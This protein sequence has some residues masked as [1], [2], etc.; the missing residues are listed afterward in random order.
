MDGL[1]CIR[2]HARAASHVSGDVHTFFKPRVFERSI[3][4]F[5]YARSA[6]GIANENG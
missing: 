1:S 2:C 6:Q 5:G 3:S 4:D